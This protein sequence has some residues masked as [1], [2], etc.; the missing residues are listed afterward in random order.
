MIWRDAK[1]K[2]RVWG[3]YYCLCQFL[4]GDLGFSH[5]EFCLTRNEW[6]SETKIISWLDPEIPEKYLPE[7]IW[8]PVNESVTTEKPKGEWTPFANFKF[9]RSKYYW[10]KD[11]GYSW[12]VDGCRCISPNIDLGSKAQIW[13]IPIEKPPR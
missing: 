13:S 9:D 1:E 2:P 11:D 6:E 8:A 3:Q 12:I 7:K 5:R 10:A 4:D